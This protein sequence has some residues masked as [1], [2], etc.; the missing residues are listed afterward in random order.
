MKVALLISLWFASLLVVAY[1]SFHNGYAAGINDMAQHV[2]ER[3][4]LIPLGSY[5]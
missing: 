3:Y 1:Y 4:R 2:I 5:L